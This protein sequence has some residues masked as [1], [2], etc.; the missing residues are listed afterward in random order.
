MRNVGGEFTAHL[1][2]F[3]LFRNV[4]YEQN[5]SGDCISAKD[6]ACVDLIAA[7]V[8]DLHYAD[9]SVSETD[10][11]KMKTLSAK[12]LERYHEKNN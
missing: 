12:I 11:E 8:G 5:G 9:V 2:C 7:R 1:L 4:K 3:F 10:L 6:R